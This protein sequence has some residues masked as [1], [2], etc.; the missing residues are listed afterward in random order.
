[1]KDHP[2]G[3]VGMQEPVDE[4]I[5]E[6]RARERA[7]GADERGP[8]DDGGV[9]GA[10][11][12]ERNRRDEP[13]DRPGGA[14]LDQGVPVRRRRPREDDRAQRPGAEPR[15]RHH[16]DEKRQARV[17]APPDRDDLVS[18]LVADQNGHQREGK[19]QARPDEMRDAPAP[20]CVDGPGDERRH[21]G[22]EKQPQG[23][24]PLRS[25]GGGPGHEQDH[26]LALPLAEQREDLQRL[27]VP[28]EA[29]EPL[30]HVRAGLDGKGRAAVQESDL[31]DRKRRRDG[32]LDRVEAR[33]RI[34]HH[35]S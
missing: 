17:D 34:A 1:M 7:D 10:V 33:F 8:R 14:E 16:R 31:L 25:A 5:D 35:G 18:H 3:R 19:R 4:E 12:E 2:A 15:D 29:Q 9:R 20:R 30:L 22:R 21:Q 13:G 28:A 32:R 23:E 24:R 11:D 27:E 6:A 26:R